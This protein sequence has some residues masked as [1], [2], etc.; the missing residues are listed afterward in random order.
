MSL[1]SE[2]GR[3]RQRQRR[4]VED[5]IG[6]SAS[7]LVVVTPIVVEQEASQREL[8]IG[9]PARLDGFDLRPGGDAETE[10]RTLP[11][12]GPLELGL[13]TD[14]G[15]IAFEIRVA[16]K[17]ENTAET[18]WIILERL[19]EGPDGDRQALHPVEGGT[20][21]EDGAGADFSVIPALGDSAGGGQGV[22]DREGD[23]EP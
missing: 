10:S 2:G 21:V 1:Q 19:R 6:G 23:S 4:G 5:C 3:D 8:E 14:P 7:A 9:Q 18:P 22:Q 11:S 15:A 20:E 16:P 12:D 17:D 13:E